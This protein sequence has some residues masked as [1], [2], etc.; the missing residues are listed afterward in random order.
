MVGHWIDT[1]IRG[2]RHRH[3]D[4]HKALTL[5]ISTLGGDDPWLDSGY[6]IPRGRRGP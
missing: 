4:R 2:L 1:R 3:G 5:I 6:P